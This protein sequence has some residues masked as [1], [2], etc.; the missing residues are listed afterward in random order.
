MGFGEYVAHVKQSGHEYLF[1]ALKMGGPDKKRGWYLSKRF[2][3]YRRSVGVTD[4]ATV[5]HS[6]R[7]TVA[8]ALERAHI[9]ENEAAQIIGHKK[10]TMSYGV[11][12]GGLDLAALKQVV[13][14][15]KYP[16]LNLS[17]LYGPR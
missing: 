3:T 12:S 10:L 17:S 5:F 16:G 15:I 2:T 9:P 8:T 13:E 4:S 11:Y 1:P 6:L 14:A 7:N